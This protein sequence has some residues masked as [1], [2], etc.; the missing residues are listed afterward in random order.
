M[1]SF[2][3]LLLIFGNAIST[4]TRIDLVQPFGILFKEVSITDANKRHDERMKKEKITSQNKFAHQF[5][6][7]RLGKPCSSV[8]KCGII[9]DM[10]KYYHPLFPFGWKVHHLQSVH[11]HTCL[12]WSTNF[13]II[14]IS[15]STIFA[16]ILFC[17]LK[18]AKN[19]WEVLLFS[20]INLTKF[21][22]DVKLTK[23]E[24]RK[25]YL[26]HHKPQFKI[27]M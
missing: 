15:S 5:S 19:L 26:W 2:F 14:F 10:E 24:E 9:C 13:F 21:F 8:K 16:T 12:D 17:F 3:L 20:F 22:S 27:E 18:L 6:S 25:K 11:I 7:H 23:R 1:K 4:T